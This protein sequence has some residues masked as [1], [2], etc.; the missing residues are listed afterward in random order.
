M[1]INNSLSL[2]LSASI[3]VIHM[4]EVGLWVLFTVHYI[5]NGKLSNQKN[6]SALHD[7]LHF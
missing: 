5:F 3:D 4:Y 7:V 6:C 1:V 2:S